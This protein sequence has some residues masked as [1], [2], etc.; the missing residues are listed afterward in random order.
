MLIVKVQYPQG[1]TE[2]WGPY[3]SSAEANRDAFNGNVTIIETYTLKVP[4]ETK[5]TFDSK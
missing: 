1:G 3:D 4:A 5:V 2:F